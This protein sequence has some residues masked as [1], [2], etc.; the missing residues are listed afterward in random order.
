MRASR[1]KLQPDQ[2]RARPQR[3]VP[4][5]PEA[6]A[7]SA[8]DDIVGMSADQLRAELALSRREV[9]SLRAALKQRVAHDGS[10][11]TLETRLRMVMDAANLGFWDW[12]LQTNAI[13]RSPEWKRQ[14]GFED[15]EISDAIGEW[16]NRLHPED[17]TRLA[18]VMQR[19]MKDPESG[20]DLEFRLQHRDGTYRW[21][22]SQGK[23]LTEKGKP[24][25]LLGVHVDV[26]SSK[27]READL[28][29]SEQRFRRLLEAAP[30]I[31]WE[32]DAQTWRFSYVGLRAQSLLGYPLTEWFEPE[33]WVKHLQAEGRDSVVAFRREQIMHRVDFDCEYGMIAQDGRVVWFHDIVHVVRGAGGTEKLQGFL[34]DITERKRA[35]EDHGRLAAIVESSNDAI[36]GETLDGIITSWN[37]SAERIYGYAAAEALGRS[38]RM[39]VPKERA[40]EVTQI[41][42]Q[43]KRGDVIEQFETVRVPRDGRPIHVSLMVSPIRDANGAITGASAIARDITERKQLEAEVLQI[44][45]REQ[46]RIARDLHD[47]LGQLLSGTVHLANVLQLELAEQALPEA[48]EASRITELLNQ[49]VTE[50]R[51]LARGLYPVRPEANGLLVA[52]E[53]L[54]A[55]TK[56]LFKIRCTLECRSTVQIGDNTVAS[57]LYRIAQEAVNNAV[58]HGQARHIQLRLTAIPQRWVL[59]IRDDGVGFPSQPTSRGGMGIRIMQYRAGMIGGSLKIER[60]LRRGVRVVCTVHR[61]SSKLVG[62]TLA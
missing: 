57:H 24:V 58:K 10:L 45:E 9:E 36:I 33:F 55:R 52:L 32:A 11:N 54:A 17:R 59:T 50:T 26:T 21:I 25:R 8:L 61:R 28:R 34:V 56:E 44:S 40:H 1:D 12:D 31:P 62:R 13:Y 18:T 38:V 7:V 37:K 51:S 6:T 41:L 19:V 39:I 42:N 47:G 29:E 48:A 4:L 27:Q 53:E 15:H 35:A 20:F 22:R 43:M 23:V 60:G 49:A 3:V 46:Q 16:Q 5:P 14:L 2:S 30:I